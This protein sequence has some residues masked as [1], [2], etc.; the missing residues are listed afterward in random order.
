MCEAARR[1]EANGLCKRPVHHAVNAGGDGIL[2][3]GHVRVVHDHLVKVAVP[4]VPQDA[5]EKAQ[6]GRIV[7]R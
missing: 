4:H 7:P 3:L 6:L 5:V 2:L 1:K